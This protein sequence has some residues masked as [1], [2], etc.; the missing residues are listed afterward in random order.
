[1]SKVALIAGAT[2]AAAK[3][4]VEELVADEWRV[5]G[6]SRTPPPSAG[7][8]TYVASDLGNADALTRALAGH[9]DI[10]H[11]FYTA[12]AAHGE[13]GVED[14]GANLAFLRHTIDAAERV[15]T[16]LAHIHLVEGTKWY[17]MHLGPFATPAREDQPR[18][19]PPN[20]YYDQQDLLAARQRGAGWTWS[21]SRPNFLCDFAPERSR[22]APVVI[23]T[24]AALC[25]ELGVPLDF[26]GSEACYRALLDVT[27]ARQL[28][29]AMVFLATS[30][31][32]RNEAFNVTNGD[33]YRWCNLWPKI[34]DFFGIS[35]GVVRPLTL[36]DWVA[37]KA[38]LWQRVVARHGLQ[39]LALADVALWPFGDFLLRQ[40]HDNI[41]STTKIRSIGFHEMVDTE[42]MFLT[43]ITRYREARV[44]P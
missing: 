13:S 18:H 9:R 15:A 6:V 40:G 39:P 25:R 11:V 12:R 14:V 19:A 10:T 38:P 1:M 28:A 17:G 41:S 20:F 26:P 23:G 36:A 8:V 22:N 33:A 34:A 32:A 3:R 5:V 42:S 7:R 35:C 43:Q 2:G 30:D 21:A 29:R 24:Y 31:H 16:N 44:L 27:D 4:L 37:D